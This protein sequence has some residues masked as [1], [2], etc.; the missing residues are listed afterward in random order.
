[1]SES[2]KPEDFPSLTAQNHQRKGLDLRYNQVPTTGCP[3]K[4]LTLGI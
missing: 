1:M 2:W 3:K 4:K